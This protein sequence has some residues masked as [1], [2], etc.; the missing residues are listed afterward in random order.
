M[1]RLAL[2]LLAISFN[3]FANDY[4]CYAPSP[5]ALALG[6]DYYALDREITLNDEAETSLRNTLQELTGKWHGTLTETSC[7]GSDKVPK[8][9]VTQLKTTA[10]LTVTNKGELR[11]KARKRGYS[12]NVEKGETLTLFIREAIYGFNHSNN[13]LTSSEKIRLSSKQASR[14]LET[15]S[16]VSYRD[17][18]L[19]LSVAYFSN[20]VYVQTLNFKLNRQ[21]D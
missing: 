4:S 11:I 6:E 12:D 21:A 3:T 17:N 13:T 8:R 16:L 10:N 9:K 14:L 7:T 15:I 1:K 5:N 19:K 20:G 2:C 18:T